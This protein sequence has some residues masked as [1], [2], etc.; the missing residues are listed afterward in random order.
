MAK[1]AFTEIIVEEMLCVGS[2]DSITTSLEIVTLEVLV[3][4]DELAELAVSFF[5][6]EE[7]NTT[8]CWWWRITIQKFLFLRFTRV[9][10]SF[11]ALLI[12]VDRL[13]NISFLSTPFLFMNFSQVIFGIE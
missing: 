13:S 4:K 5:L 6:K 3:V 10:A 9:S 2:D 7:T 1:H 8:L 12:N 11:I